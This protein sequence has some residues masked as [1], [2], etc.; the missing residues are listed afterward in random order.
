MPVLAGTYRRPIAELSTRA[1]SSAWPVSVT[2]AL[3]VVFWPWLTLVSLL[4]VLE[5]SRLRLV[6]V[7]T[8]PSASGV[9][10][11]TPSGAAIVRVL[12]LSS[13]PRAALKAAVILASLLE[14]SP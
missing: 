10:M 9:A 11:P 5:N 14:D 2:R 4:Q 8:E 1:G 3:R 6:T 7:F 12:L 13:M